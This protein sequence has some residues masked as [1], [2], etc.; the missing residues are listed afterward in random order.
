[1]QIYPLPR[2]HSNLEVAVAEQLTGA[3]EPRGLSNQLQFVCR[4]AAS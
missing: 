4:R 2:E 1:M 3:W